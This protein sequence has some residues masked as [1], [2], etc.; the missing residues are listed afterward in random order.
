[1]AL[2]YYWL[3]NLAVERNAVESIR[4]ANASIR[5][6]LTMMLRGIRINTDAL[7]AHIDKLDWRIKFFENKV[8]PILVG[9][10]LNP[11]SPAQ[12]AKYLYQELGLPKPA[13]GEL[14]G[15]KTMFK[16]LLKKDIPAVKIILAV[17]RWSREK[18]Q[19]SFRLWNGDRVTCAYI[20]TGT[21]SFRLSSRALLKYKTQFEGYGTNIQNWNKDRIRYLVVPD[22]CNTITKS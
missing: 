18:G 20:V 8:L 4:Q 21:E 14:T 6:Y 1:M 13:K 7:C 16:I 3:E 17:R 22:V 12:V 10:P 9:H 15:K 5:V 11:R 19:I 2:A